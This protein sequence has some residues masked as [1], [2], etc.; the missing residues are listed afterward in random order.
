MFLNSETLDPRK[1]GQFYPR[2]KRLYE[3]ILDKGY[4]AQA[5]SV[6]WLRE[7]MGEICEEENPPQYNDGNLMC[8]PPWGSQKF[9]ERKG[10]S[11]EDRSRLT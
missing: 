11:L 7:R 10:E 4:G 5:V 2:Q 9:Q 3:E 1:F 8:K 6:C